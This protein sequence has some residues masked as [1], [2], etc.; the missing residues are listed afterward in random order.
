MIPRPRQRL[1]FTIEELNTGRT[2]TI[3][4]VAESTTLDIDSDWP[5]S[6]FMDL[7]PYEVAPTSYKVAVTGE[8]II[9]Y[10]IKFGQAATDEQPAIDGSTR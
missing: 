3:T 4:G 9:N 1:T 8:R 7:Y 5:E 6:D 2:I 10:E